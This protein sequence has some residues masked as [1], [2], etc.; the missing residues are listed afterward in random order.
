MGT[1][2]GSLHWLDVRDNY[3]RAQDATPEQATGPL[4]GPLEAY[5]RRR[6]QRAEEFAG[7]LTEDAL[8][9]LSMEQALALYRAAGGGR[10]GEFKSNNIG[11]IRESLDFLLYDTIKLEGRFDECASQG[12]GY[13]LA[14]AG[15]EFVSYVLCLRDPVLFTPWN[16]HTERALRRLGAY[17]ETLRHGPTGVRYVELLEALR[18]VRQR[19]GLSDFR[20]LDELLYLA[21]RTAWKPGR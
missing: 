19:L 9:L 12:G 15:K 8:P 13:R 11:E 17:P 20:E 7:W 1:K 16:P 10:T 3:R 4:S 6:W 2:P 5:R 18:P 14:G 21:A